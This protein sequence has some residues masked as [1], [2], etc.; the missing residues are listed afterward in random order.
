MALVE[1]P[2]GGAEPLPEAVPLLL[3]GVDAL[4][5]GIEGAEPFRSIQPGARLLSLEVEKLADGVHSR[6]QTRVAVQ[7]APDHLGRVALAQCPQPLLDV[8][9]PAPV[10]PRPRVHHLTAP[11]GPLRGLVAHDEM[12]AAHHQQRLGQQ[13]LA[14]GRLLGLHL[15]DFTQED[16]LPHALGRSQVD[17]HPL[18]VLDPLGGR[19][20]HL[21]VRVEP[22]GCQG[23]LLVA[24]HVAAFQ[25][26]ALLAGEVQ[27]HALS[28]ARRLHR[29]A[30]HL[31]AAD[32]EL[33][34]AR[35]RVDV[36][37]GAHLARQPGAG[38]DDAVALQ[39]EHAV[40]RQPEEAAGGRPVDVRQRVEDPLPHLFQSVSRDGREARHRR[41]FQR[42]FE[43][44]DLDLLL[45]LAHPSLRHQVHLGDDEQR[46]PH[47][48]EVNDVEVLLGLRHD[49]VVRR[50]RE[51][52]E[53]DAVGAGEHVADEA[54]VAGHVDDAC[55]AAVGQRQVR[56]P[57]VDG[58][59]A[60]LLLLEAVGVLAGEGL[61]EARLAVV[62]VAGG[63]DDVRHG[64]CSPARVNG[65]R[66]FR[67]GP[68]GWAPATRSRRRSS[69]RG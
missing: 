37:A 59:A 15:L 36:V 63:S 3:G 48:Q 21:Q 19:G 54:L 2:Q 5:F 7:K 43:G 4:A 32:A 55:L 33:L 29:L 56:E 58:D 42:G 13:H 12:V 53:V 41:S 66:A 20:A 26:A 65:K 1:R 52:H 24:D 49:P 34:A 68:G 39:H 57:Q 9:L 16:Q 6:R 28:P 8:H 31:D 30:V 38:D 47:P 45:H 62:D 25:G 67:A 22:R 10:A 23:Q 18:V 40:H 11:Q 60:L 35:D 51:Q 61:D 44:E 46:R 14:V 27:G 17:P 69:G 50:H 64:G